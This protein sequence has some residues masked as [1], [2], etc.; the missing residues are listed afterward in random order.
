MLVGFCRNEVKLCGTNGLTRFDVIAPSGSIFTFNPVVATQDWI[1]ENEG[2]EGMDIN[3]DGSVD[4]LDYSVADVGFS[5]SEPNVQLSL[6][7]I[8]VLCL[9]GSYLLC[10]WIVNSRL[11]KILVA[12]RDDEP[13]LNF[14]GY[15]PYT[16]KIFAFCIAAVLAGLA[17]L[18]YVPQMK[19][20]TPSNM[21]AVRSVLVVVWVAV[22]GRGSL[23]GAILGAL[24]VNLLYN[25]LTSEQSIGPINWSQDYWPIFLGVMFVLVVLFLPKGL[26]EIVDKF[27]G[28]NRNKIS[29]EGANPDMSTEQSEI[30]DPLVGYQEFLPSQ[31]QLDF[32]SSKFVL[33]VENLSVSFDGFKAVDIPNYGIRHGELRVIIGPNGAGKTTFCDLVSGKTRPSTGKVYFDGREI[34]MMDE[35]EISL[36]GIGRKF[37]TP[38]VFD[39]LS[40]YENLLIALPEIRVGEKISL[41]RKQKRKPIRFWKSLKGLV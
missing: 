35:S 18:L 33:F 31:V 30:V 10:R 13:T 26:I 6:Y 5:L 38:T 23:G 15:K 21:E 20:V 8:T 37:Q 36:L 17:S 9:L 41:N 27:T 22:G 1:Q 39:S 2:K 40:T 3:Q 34:S 14:F 12:I 19:I 24:S 32:W 16:F 28:K 4:Q 11:G 25:F 7:L 29:G